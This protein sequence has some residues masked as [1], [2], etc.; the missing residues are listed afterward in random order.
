MGSACT[1]EICVDSVASAIASER[2]GGAR[3][4]LCS[5]VV[6]GGITPSVGLIARVR[7][8][9]SLPIHVMIRPRGGDFCY[10]G[11]EFEILRRD[12]AQ[13]RT[14]GV[15][16][17]VLGILDVHGN[18]DVD[19]TRRLVD[20][21]R[22]LSVTFHRAFDMSNHLIRALEGVCATG[23]DRVLTSGGEQTSL[24]G[25]DV[26]QELVRNIGNKIVVMAGSGIKPENARGFIDYTGVKEIHVGLRSRIP[27]PMVH[28][29]P[30]IGMGSIEGREYDRFVVLQEEVARLCEAIKKTG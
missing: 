17:V 9:V 28:R 11:Y 23:C 4:E 30:R 24:Q 27:G 13:A 22:P 25:R 7:E 2:G 1:V 26:I 6:E 16:G 19:R 29:N 5:S 21:A 20:E 8:A 10:D 18:V 3:L 15:N 14:L 12:I